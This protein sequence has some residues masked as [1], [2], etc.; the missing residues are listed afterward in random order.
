MSRGRPI[1]TLERV[2][3]LLNILKEAKQIHIRGIARVLKINPFTASKLIENYFK[4]YVDV[5][6]MDQFG[7]RAKIL[8]LKPGRENLTMEEILRYNR[9]KKQLRDR[10]V[11]S[12]H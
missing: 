3:S 12:D 4:P 8:S 5:N 10:G 6:Y 9:L 1:K 7:I 2:A 11:V